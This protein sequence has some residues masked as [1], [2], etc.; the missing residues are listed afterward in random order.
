MLTQMR[1]NVG[2]WIIKLLLGAIVVVFVLWGVGSNQKTPNAVVATVDG[3]A[4]G[5]LEYSRTY[6]NLLDNVRRQFGDNA[7][8][9]LLKAL[10]LEEQA[11]NQLIDRRI[12]VKAADQMGFQIS[13]A[14][15]AASIRAIPAFQSTSGFDTRAYQQVLGRLGL[16]PEAFEAAQREDLLIQ[17]VSDFVSRAVNVSD[18]EILAWYQW[19]QT[20][21]NLDY[22][23]VDP[24]AYAEVAVSAEEAQAYFAENQEAYKTAPELKARYIVFQPADYKSRVHITD[25]DVRR[26][27]EENPSEFFS[28]EKVEA[29]HILLKVPPDADEAAVEAARQEAA[30][31]RAQA[32]AGEDFAELAQS[33]S[34][35][36]SRN[37]GG[38][39]GFFERGRM[40]KPFEEAAFALQAG[41]I[42]A[43]V[44]T[45]FGW[46]IIKVETHQAAETLPFD[47]SQDK[48]RGLLTDRKARAMAL[49]D[50]ESAYDTSY[51]GDDLLV[52][53]ERYG[54]AVQ[55]TDWIA[56]EDPV[57]GVSASR[58][59]TE[60]A[61]GLEPM[62]VSEVQELGGDFFLIQ[63]L[64]KRPSRIPALEAVRAR[65][66]EDLK[67]QKRWDQAE[68]RARE[69][70]AALGNGAPLEAVAA[71]HG[72]TVQT[73][74]WFKRGEAIPGI[75]ANPALTAAAFD[76]TS[77]A[78]LPQDP[79]RGEDA[80]FLFH[81]RGQRI[82]GAQA[83]I[84]ERASLEQ[85]LR[86]RKQQAV[87]QN[88][89]AQAR[90]R[91]DIEIDR[92]LLQ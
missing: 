60:T 68:A 10:N 12:L 8:E 17:K 73:T 74:G 59:F 71:A 78:P 25:E 50:A 6:R 18:E 29:R 4:I 58:Q 72:L 11:I 13:D 21:V 63:T 46:H 86:Q 28:P 61:F 51:G 52:A 82:P 30:A 90:S 84:A 5:Y 19:Q 87:Y 7:N 27:Y 16:T 37:Q 20:S 23:R 92:T 77:E 9:D 14:E 76:L 39:L 33:V 34:E 43:P 45:D 62:A 36:P 57:T 81:F 69:M 56:R 49:E 80:V 64:E 3:E 53:A 41:E 85:Q 2:S 67:T 40:V 79:L 22:L 15:L 26:Y 47:A 54:V 66:V 1:K 24:G 83:D 55:T 38:Y 44:R 91:V 75:G 88:W 42:S 70:L 48:I 32:V 65:V 35:G 89:M 31:I